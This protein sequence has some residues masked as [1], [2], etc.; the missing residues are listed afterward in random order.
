LT[1]LSDNALDL[2]RKRYFR[3]GETTW[4]DLCARVCKGISQAETTEEKIKEVYDRIYNMMVNME[5]IAGTPCL[6]NADKTNSGQ[7][8]S[9][10]IISIKDNIE[11]IYHAKSECAKI[12]QK[13]GGVGFNISTLRPKG[14]IVETSKGYSCGVIGFMEEFDLTADVVTRNNIRKGAIKIDLNDWHPDLIDFVNC[15]NDITKLTHMNISVSIS[16]KFMNAVKNNEDWKL[17]FPDYSTN[18]EVYNKEWD[19]NID[20]WISKGYPIKVYRTIKAKELYTEIMEHA[21]KTGEPGVSFRDLMNESN[22]NPHMGRVDSTNP[23]LYKDTYMVTENGLEKISNIKSRIWNSKNYTESQTW[24]TGIKKVVRIMTKS[25]FEYITTPD[26]KFLLQNNEWCEAQNLIGKK[27]KFEI[28]EKDWVGKNSHSNCN[29]KILGFEFGDASF[30]KA[31]DRMKYLYCTGG[32]DFEVMDIIEKEFHDKF[33]NK[34]ST[35]MVI[36]IPYGTIYANA[37]FDKLNDRMIPD[38]IM[39]LP[40]KEMK[41]FIQGVFSANG[42]NLKKYNK[43]SLTGVNREMLKQMQQLLLLFGIKAKLWYHNKRQDIEF[44]NGIYTCNQSC[45][46]IISRDSYRKFCDKIGFIQSYKNGYFDCKYKND[47]TFET[48]ILISELDEAEVWDFTESELHMGI[49]NGAYV[50]NCGEFNSIPYNSCNLGSVN[51]TTCITNNQFDWDKFRYIVNNSVRFLDNM[52]TVN[53]LPI[54]KINNV[55]KSLRSIGLGVM[56]LADCLY[57]LKIPY[58]KPEGYK[59]INTLF[60]FMRETAESYSIKLADEKGIYD[61]WEGSIWYRNNIKVRNSNFLSI[62]PTG[63]ISFIANVSSGLEPNFALTYSRRTNEGDLYFTTNPIFENELKIRGIHSKELLQ[64]INDNKGSCVGIKEIPK[65]MQEI[66]VVA[67]DILPKQHADVVGIIQK[68]VDLAT[69]KTIN[70]PNSATI[71]DVE[72]I[73]IYS[74]ELGCKGITVYRDGCRENQTLSV[75]RDEVKIDNGVKFNSVEPIKK[76]DLGETY[77]TNVKEKVAC[78]NLYLNLCRDE[79]GNLSEMFINTSKGGICQ[80]N[81]NAISR[82]VSMALRGGIKVESICDQLMGIKCP[83]CTILRSQG[84]DINTSCPDAIG[85]Y[86]LEKYQLGNTT[87]IEKVQRKKKPTKQDKM[88]CPN[89]GEKMRLESGCCICN[90]G[91]SL[92][93]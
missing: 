82:L 3:E 56:G 22:P 7:L 9:C 58:N 84:K 90:C 43:I 85:S 74:W 6:I 28:Q 83:A 68:Y 21:W 72:D 79:S 70:L 92:C 80:S 26:H 34:E 53:K 46:L 13:N 62:A 49:T 42:C 2:L 37:F 11:S 60:K 29:Y 50:H 24:K 81:I 39:Q 47:E 23:C 86:I 16:D 66:F 30:H 55:T 63:S 91:Y 69:S 5:F 75:K 33:Y 8:S 71:K 1:T 93:T 73:Y 14:T 57:M 41:D 44:S 12:F 59:F 19:G 52:I 51:L 38:W 35:S 64:K 88:K 10:F 67:S 65:D 4:E 77:G 89:C 45:H 31:S 54:E 78:G 36:N 20:D 18:K 76:D 17:I 61:A 15:K 27:I 87:I 40:K 32:K 48:V 25:G